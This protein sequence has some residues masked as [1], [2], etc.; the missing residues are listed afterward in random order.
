MGRRQPETWSLQ[1]AHQRSTTRPAVKAAAKGRTQTG[2]TMRRAKTA[3]AMQQHACTRTCPKASTA[4][5][6]NDSAGAATMIYSPHLKMRI[7]ASNAAAAAQD[8][9]LPA[10][11]PPASM[12]CCDLLRSPAHA[13]AHMHSRLQ[14][15]PR[16]TPCLAGRGW[17]AAAAARRLAAAAPP[18]TP[19]AAPPCSLAGSAGPPGEQRQ[20]QAARRARCEWVRG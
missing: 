14:S 3:C 19:A 4:Q 6:L 12:A 1:C 18:A 9:P 11:L 17:A 10:M 13:H 2:N 8:T 16:L 7:S 5:L 15:Q 20:Q